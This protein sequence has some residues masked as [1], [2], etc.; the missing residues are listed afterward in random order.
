MA[1]RKGI[2]TKLNYLVLEDIVFRADEGFSHAYRD[3]DHYPVI[4]CR[5]R[6]GG[7]NINAIIGKPIIYCS[8]G[9]GVWL[10]KL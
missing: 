9:I 7:E 5:T 6:D 4:G 8:K 3:S 2:Y 1:S 10:D